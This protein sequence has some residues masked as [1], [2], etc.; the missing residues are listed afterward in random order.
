MYPRIYSKSAIK[1]ISLNKD[2]PTQVCCLALYMK[3][4]PDVQW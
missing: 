2:V 1:Q 4:T 3:D